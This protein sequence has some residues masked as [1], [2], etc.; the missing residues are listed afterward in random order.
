MSIRSRQNVQRM[1]AAPSRQTA[2]YKK[3][4]L[5]AV[6]WRPPTSATQTQGRRPA[7]FAPDSALEEAGFELSV[8]HDTTK[9]SRTASC[10]FQPDFGNEK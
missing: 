9:L 3:D 2:I 5:G 6:S 4:R 8:P 7:E 10:R 1:S